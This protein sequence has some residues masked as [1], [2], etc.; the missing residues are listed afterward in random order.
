MGI[1]YYTSTTLPFIAGIIISTVQ[2]GSCVDY[3]ILMTNR[4]LF[5]RQTGKDKYAA[6]TI[7]SQTCS[8]SILVSALS[9]FAATFGVGLYSN[10][11]MKKLLIVYYSWSS[12]NTKKIA[13]MLQS[14]AG[15]DIEAIETVRPYAGS[16]DDVV[17]Q[18]Q[19]EVKAGFQPEIKKLSHAGARLCG[20]VRK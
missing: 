10:I 7:A 13:E 8:K 5:E 15:A 17:E 19:K 9:F 18:A 16:Y 12:G 2:L 3:A 14:A 1:C 6:L 11:D 20:A 4:Y